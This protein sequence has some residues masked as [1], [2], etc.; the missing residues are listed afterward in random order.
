MVH[1]PI[2]SYIFDVCVPRLPNSVQTAAKLR[3]LEEK[4]VLM[5]QHVYQVEQGNAMQ[6]PYSTYMNL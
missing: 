6:S 3:Y 4:E 5:Y 2:F 1:I